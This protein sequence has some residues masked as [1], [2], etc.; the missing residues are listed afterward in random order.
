[1]FDGQIDPNKMYL[2][3]AGW[4][5][6]KAELLTLR[7]EPDAK[8]N[9]PTLEACLHMLH[10]NQAGLL[11]PGVVCIDLLGTDSHVI[12]WKGYIWFDANALD[13]PMLDK[14]ALT[15]RN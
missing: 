13:E 15:W 7:P 9:V 3:N 4:V 1:M 6:G 5:Y 8:G 14:E 10:A 12:P 11:G 2:S